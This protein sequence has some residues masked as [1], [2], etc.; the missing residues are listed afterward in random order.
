MVDKSRGYNLPQ[1]SC[2]WGRT[3]KVIEYEGHCRILIQQTIW[4]PKGSDV[5]IGTQPEEERMQAHR[6]METSE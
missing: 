3:H 5:S 4:R 6:F 1:A 2:I